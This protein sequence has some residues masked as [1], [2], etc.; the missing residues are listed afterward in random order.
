MILGLE[1]GELEAMRSRNHDR[2]VAR[3]DNFSCDKL[4]KTCQRHASVRTTEHT[5]EV[6]LGDSFTQL[7]FRRLFDD[8]IGERH[9]PQCPP[10]TY[11]RTNLN[12]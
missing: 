3:S 12:R 9:P 5:R 8:S 10:N 1:V 4:L 2:S 7:G 6:G 11:W